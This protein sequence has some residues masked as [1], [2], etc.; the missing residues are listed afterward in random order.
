[1]VPILKPDQVAELPDVAD[2]LSDFW[3]ASLYVLST[4]DPLQGFLELMGCLLPL[5]SSLQ[6]IPPS[7]D[8]FFELF[9]SALDDFGIPQALDESEV[10]R[11]ASAKAGLALIAARSASRRGATFG[12]EENL[13]SVTETFDLAVCGFV[14]SLEEQREARPH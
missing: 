9:D 1:M 7:Y 2:M 3:R 5:V 12:S 8:Y 11:L 4:A 13:C 14:G 6:A 10:R